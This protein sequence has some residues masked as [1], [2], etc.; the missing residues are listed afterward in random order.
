MKNKKTK[1]SQKRILTVVGEGQTEK[2][3]VEHL[4]QFYSSGDLVVKVKSANGKGPD[5]VIND[6]IGTL[7]GSSKGVMV[8]ALLD[9][10]LIWPPKLIKEAK[11]LNI[12]LVGVDPCIEALMIDILEHRRPRPCNN[13]S[14]KKYLHPLLDGKPTDKRSYVTLFTNDVLNNAKTRVEELDQIISLFN[15]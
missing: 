15:S 1:R 7:N 9:K 2:A 3:F 10:D 12:T 14:C 13:K 11:R 4:R 8:A 5:N 6:A